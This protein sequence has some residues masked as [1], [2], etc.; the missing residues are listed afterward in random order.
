MLTPCWY[1]GKPMTAEY[2][3]HA[4]SE[5]FDPSRESTFTFLNQLMQEVKDVFK[6]QFL[7]AG[8]DEA[9]YMCW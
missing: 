9:H 3:Q 8:M 6:D 5:N 1:D 2:G 4:E 7:H